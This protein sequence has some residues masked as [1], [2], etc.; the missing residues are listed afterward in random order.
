MT[1]AVSIAQLLRILI[2]WLPKHTIASLIKPIIHKDRFA[3]SFYKHLPTQNITP[4]IH[5]AQT[6]AQNTDLIG[7]TSMLS[8]HTH[9]LVAKE[10]ANLTLIS[11]PFAKYIN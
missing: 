9:L 2:L 8:G 3:K 5:S 4:G 6:R 7:S 1:P 10:L 11:Y